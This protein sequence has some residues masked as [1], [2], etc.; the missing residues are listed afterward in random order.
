[1]SVRL[2]EY[3]SD[4]SGSN[5]QFEKKKENKCKDLKNIYLL[6]YSCDSKN[7]SFPKL[8][9]RASR[10]DSTFLMYYHV[11]NVISAN[12]RKIVYWFLKSLNL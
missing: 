6:K 7:D 1:M 11:A 3:L 2:S 4:I 5:L 10:P 9:I 12:S 8:Q